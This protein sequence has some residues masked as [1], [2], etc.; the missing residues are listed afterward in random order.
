MP[1]MVND[2]DDDEALGDVDSILDV[3]D[4]DDVSALEVRAA[5][6]DLLLVGLG[7]DAEDDNFANDFELLGVIGGGAD[8]CCCCGD[9][10]CLL[11][12]VL[13]L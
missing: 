1:L 8:D 3:L 9:E 6:D 11:G 4:D 10:L 12:D 5:E 7:D 2:R 13:V